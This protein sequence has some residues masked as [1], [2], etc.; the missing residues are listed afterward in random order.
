MADDLRSQTTRPDC[1]M[2]RDNPEKCHA[3]S[4][5]ADGE[6]WWS[7]CPA[8]DGVCPLHYEEYADE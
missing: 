8:K 4:Y 1:I 3:A 6:C 2:D 7:E 5:R